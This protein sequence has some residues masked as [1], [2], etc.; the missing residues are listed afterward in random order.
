MATQANIA[1]F[2]HLFNKD[3]TELNELASFQPPVT[4]VYNMTVTVAF[5]EIN[6]KPAVEASFKIKDTVQ[7]EAPEGK[8]KA[9]KPGD[10]F[11]IAFILLTKEGQ[12]NETAEGKMREFLEYFVAYAGTTNVEELVTGKIKDVEIT[13]TVKTKVDPKD[14]D[15]YRVDVK[16]I[17]IA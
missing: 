8:Q 5:K 17:V 7:A 3:I 10:E 6:Q 12:P 11:S 16:D 15:R 14:E 9:A 1:A 13:A 2:A 4:G